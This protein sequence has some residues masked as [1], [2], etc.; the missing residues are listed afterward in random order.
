LA[1]QAK[2]DYHEVLGVV[3]TASA[4]EIKDWFDK[5]AAELKMAGKPGNI[6]DVEKI[7]EIVTAYRVLCDDKK[8]TRYDQT[9]QGSLGAEE[10]QL[11]RPGRDKLD[12]LIEWI[13]DRREEQT[14]SFTDF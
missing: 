6:E 3:R 12:D 7:R 8:R 11:A 2:R 4:T 10:N 13:E 5:R 9:G 14:S 1:T